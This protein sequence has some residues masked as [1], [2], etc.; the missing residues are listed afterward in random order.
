MPIGEER[1]I[2]FEGK[3]YRLV[4]TRE[5]GAAIE[6]VEAA[7]EGGG[8]GTTF[9]VHIPAGTL[10]TLSEDDLPLL[11]FIARTLGQRHY[12][13][14][15]V[16]LH[17]GDAE[18]VVSGVEWTTVLALARTEE[19]RPGQV[20][21]QFDDHDARRLA[22]GLRRAEARFREHGADGIPGLHVDGLTAFF[23]GG[24]FTVTDLEAPADS[25]P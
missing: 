6:E 11:V 5:V 4:V 1:S 7:A 3:P 25:T 19:W 15:A 2:A 17:R 10:S 14:H 12:F 18:F 23:E 13:S 8:E 20:G 24:A 22:K 9:R 21:R 16:G